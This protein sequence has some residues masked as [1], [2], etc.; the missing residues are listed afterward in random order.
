MVAV[1]G[2]GLAQV[3]IIARQK[4]AAPAIGGGSS[5]GSGSGGGEDKEDVFNI[6]GQSQ[7]SQL[8]GAIQGQFDKPLKAY[9]VARDVTNQQGI[10]SNIEGNASIGG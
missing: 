3:A 1:I 10:D 9:V 7:G 2:T 6:V 5:G 4:Y 8:A